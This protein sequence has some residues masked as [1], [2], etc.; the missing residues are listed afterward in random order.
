[1]EHQRKEDPERRTGN[2]ECEGGPAQNPRAS[3]VDQRRQCVP[4]HREPDS[5]VGIRTR[6][7][8]SEE[9]LFLD[10]R[11]EEPDDH[12]QREADECRD[13]TNP[14]GSPSKHDAALAR[15]N[16][17]EWRQD[18]DQHRHRHDVDAERADP[19]WRRDHR[20][21]RAEAS[22]LGVVVHEPREEPAQEEQA[23]ARER[24]N[25][26]DDRSLGSIPL[27]AAGTEQRGDSLKHGS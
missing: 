12:S 17:D 14:S 7:P 23:R 9:R 25:P 2:R 15:E 3:T 20:V 22:A 24:E 16:L 10:D 6:E 18:D 8:G 27:G 13:K 19:S 11:D 1:M 26:V 21:L 5:G 4:V